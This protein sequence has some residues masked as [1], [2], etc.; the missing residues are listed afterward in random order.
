MENRIRELREERKMTQ[1]RLSMELEVSQETVSGYENGK[2]L[3]TLAKLIQM[4]EIFDASIDYIILRSDIRTP[5][6]SDCLSPTEV[7]LFRYYRL[8]GT[9]QKEKAI[10]YI[11]GL[12]DATQN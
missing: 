8:L 7:R 4:S 10:A 12:Y 11:Q 1:R 5:I 3:P 6:T 2:Y 9:L